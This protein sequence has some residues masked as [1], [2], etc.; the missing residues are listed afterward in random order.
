MTLLLMAS[1]YIYLA[2]MDFSNTKIVSVSFN[3][4]VVISFGI[5]DII[6]SVV[7]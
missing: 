4:I 1:I 2:L 3:L 5:E 6:L 7:I